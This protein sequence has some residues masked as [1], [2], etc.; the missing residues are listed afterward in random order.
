MEGDLPRMSL[1]VSSDWLPKY[2]KAILLFLD[3]L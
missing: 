2:I 3:I 1:K